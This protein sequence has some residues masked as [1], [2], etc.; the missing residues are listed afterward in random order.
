MLGFPGC[1]PPTDDGA[2]GANHSCNTFALDSDGTITSVEVSELMLVT[3]RC[4]AFDSVAKLAAVSDTT[5]VW[6]PRSRPGRSA[7]R[8]ACDAL[9][10]PSAESRICD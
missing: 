9:T 8:L 2:G 6:L 4:A 5:N 7:R 1:G 3:S 10:I